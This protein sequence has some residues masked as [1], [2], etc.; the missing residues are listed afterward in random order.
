MVRIFVLHCIFAVLTSRGTI[1]LL[2][3]LVTVLAQN[4]LDIRGFLL[5]LFTLIVGFA[6]CFQLLLPEEDTFGTVRESLLST[7][8]L[9]VVGQYETSWLYESQN[10]TLAIM[11]FVL[12]V[13]SIL[14]V[15][16]NALIS[17]LSDSYAR[18]QENAVANRRR[19]KADLVV[20]YM[21]LLPPWRRRKIEHD[22]KYFHALL[23]ADAD[24]DLIVDDDGWEGG[25]KS[26]M[27]DIE[28]NSEKHSDAHQKA[29]EDLKNDFE[30]DMNALKNEML[31]ILRD[32]S[33]DVKTI[34]K[35]Q[36]ASN[37]GV[38]FDGRRVSG[39]VK[40]IGQVGSSILSPGGKKS[41]KTDEDKV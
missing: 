37:R 8:E 23:Q 4:F 9:T 5:V 11:T 10:P 32:L 14:V 31:S 15:V 27:D 6:V 39:A 25:L 34:K 1:L 16:L 19:E 20:E 12:A 22:S 40:Q 17:L 28:K 35:V 21:S 30:Q 41:S 36:G 18:V 13:T 2:G 29:I 33:E 3:W 24:G 7:F 26:L 38:V